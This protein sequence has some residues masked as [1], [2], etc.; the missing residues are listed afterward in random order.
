MRKRTS[1]SGTIYVILKQTSHLTFE[2]NNDN[3]IM[4]ME[5]NL[6]ESLCRVQRLIKLLNSHQILIDHPSGKPILPSS[7]RCLKG[8]G[9]PNRHTHSHAHLIIHFDV[10]FP[11]K[12]FIL[13]AENHRQVI[14]S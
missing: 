4:K 14:S 9:M 12:N 2:R 3:L 7:Y 5:I 1:G 11:D 8:Y 6:T 10:K 13:T